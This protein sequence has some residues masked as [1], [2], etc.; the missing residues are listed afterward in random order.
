M[1]WSEISDSCSPC[2]FKLF[3]FKHSFIYI[4][5]TAHAQYGLTR[6]FIKVTLLKTFCIC[7][8]YQYYLLIS[9]MAFFKS[10]R[11]LSVS[12]NL[13]KNT[14]RNLKTWEY[15]IQINDI[16]MF[17]Y[18]FILST[19]YKQEPLSTTHHVQVICIYRF[20]LKSN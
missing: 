9:S 7:F 15:A 13:I 3:C 14:N 10:T 8:H 11:C 6:T 5:D 20:N 2:R 19:N 18:G 12:E 1:I 16:L 4:T 17:D